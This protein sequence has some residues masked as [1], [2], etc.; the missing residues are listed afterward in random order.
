MTV[1]ITHAPA[2]VL[3]TPYF[4]KVYGDLL[5]FDDEYLVRALEMIAFPQR[6]F[7]IVKSWDDHILEVTTPEYPSSVPL[8]IDSRFGFV[9]DALPERPSM[10][11]KKVILNRLM[12]KVGIPYVWGGNWSQGLS[13]WIKWYPPPSHLSSLERAHWTLSGLDCSGLLY[14]ATNG[15]V[16]RNTSQLM[17][18]G[19]EISLEDI[20]PLDLILFPGHVI[21]VLNESETIESHHKMGGV[22]ILPLRKRLEMIDRP[23]TFRRFFQM[24]QDN[25]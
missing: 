16:P 21:I 3:N 18:Y 7:H 1:F 6:A 13:E 14:E 23:M 12:D 22:T 25:A 4:S 8:Y 15:L 20:K 24:P 19:R 11:S 9:G 10:P 17:S 5:P 2:P